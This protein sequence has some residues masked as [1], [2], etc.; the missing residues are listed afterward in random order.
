MSRTVIAVKTNASRD[1][2]LQ[3]LS[4]ELPRLGYTDRSTPTERIWSKN[5]GVM[6]KGQRISVNFQPGEVYLSA[7][8]HDA[9]LGESDLRGIV[10]K[11]MKSHLKQVL[12]Q[13]A[14]GIAALPAA[15]FA[16]PQ[17]VIYCSVC[18]NAC[19]PGSSFCTRCGSRL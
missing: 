2:V 3:Y 13:I 4:V 19:K 16:I 5:D 7:W 12:D 15:P 14:A 6:V 11:P 10:A 8:L 17:N 1:S 9:L 18:G